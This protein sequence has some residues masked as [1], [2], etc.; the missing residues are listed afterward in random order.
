MATSFG[1]SAGDVIASPSLGHGSKSLGN[2]SNVFHIRSMT[3]ERDLSDSA[4]LGLAKEA[5]TKHYGLEARHRE[6]M[7]YSRAL[8][9]SVLGRPSTQRGGQRRPSRFSIGRQP[10]LLHQTAT[11]PSYSANQVTRGEWTHRFYPRQSS[12]T[13]PQYAGQPPSKQPHQI[14]PAQ[15]NLSQSR[16]RAIQFLGH[17]PLALLQPQ[18]QPSLQNPYRTPLPSG[19]ELLG[20]P[21]LI[22]QPVRTPRRR[23]RNVEKCFNCRRSKKRVCVPY[24]I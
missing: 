11:Q 12:L 21:G 8:D 9:L 16:Y 22:I 23:L 7:E 14:N 4:T 10:P 15:L 2:E 3:Q 19:T 5:E 17:V 20:S 1:Y 13:L 24:V 18:S 6:R